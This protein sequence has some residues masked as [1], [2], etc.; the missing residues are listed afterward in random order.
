[1]S[2]DHIS[3]ISHEKGHTLDAFPNNVRN[4]FHQILP[5]SRQRQ[6]FRLTSKPGDVHCVKDLPDQFEHSW[7][8]RA[9]F[10]IIPRFQV[11]KDLEYGDLAISK[12]ETVSLHL[13]SIRDMVWM[14]LETMLLSFLLRGRWIV[15]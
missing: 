6:C 15:G 14:V 2:T 3:R 9:H 1:M 13:K 12:Q 10:Q 8:I 11:E 7:H 5:E 4:I